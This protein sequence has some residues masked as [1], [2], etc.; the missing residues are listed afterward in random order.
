MNSVTIFG[1]SYR[2]GQNFILANIEVFQSESMQGFLLPIESNERQLFCSE[3]KLCH[4][5][6]YFLK[7]FENK[8]SNL[9]KSTLDNIVCSKQ[10]VL[11]SRIY[12]SISNLLHWAN[13][14]FEKSIETSLSLESESISMLKLPLYK[15]EFEI[16]REIKRACP[17]SLSGIKV[18]PAACSR[19]PL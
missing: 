12:F 5:G 7:Y 1:K 2:L 10:I 4:R 13:F 17:L 6:K 14:K 19:K 16:Q 11:L 3:K 9:F 15:A 18:K 8:R